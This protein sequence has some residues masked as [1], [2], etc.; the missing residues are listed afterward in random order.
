MIQCTCLNNAVYALVFWHWKQKQ[1]NTAGDC[2]TPAYFFDKYVKRNP[3]V[4]WPIFFKQSREQHHSSRKCRAEHPMFFPW[5]IITVVSHS[6][7]TIK[8]Y[9]D[10]KVTSILQSRAQEWFTTLYMFLNK[11]VH[12]L[13]Q[14]RNLFKTQSIIYWQL[15]FWHE[16]WLIVHIYHFYIFFIIVM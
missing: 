1:K 16:T 15:K 4:L 13:M 11:N 8:I 5:Q 12:L 7:K 14:Q 2:V 10:D 6:V 3:Y 9:D